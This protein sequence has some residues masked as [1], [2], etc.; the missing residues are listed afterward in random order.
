[1]PRGR[2]QETRDT[3]TAAGLKLTGA[4]RE[5]SAAPDGS[6]KQSKLLEIAGTFAEIDDPSQPSFA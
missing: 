6:T 2:P 1:M 5:Y 3:L 4:A